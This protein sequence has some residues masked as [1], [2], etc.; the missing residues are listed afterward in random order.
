MTDKQKLTLSE[1][2]DRPDVPIDAETQKEI[3]VLEILFP[4]KPVQT[5]EYQLGED[6]KDRP[7]SR[8]IFD[9][10]KKHS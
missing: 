9:W 8:E 4:E 1:I 2:M 6:P 5:P 10:V 3:D 7:L